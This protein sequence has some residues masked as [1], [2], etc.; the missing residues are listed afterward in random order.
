[1]LN[2][3]KF[4]KIKDN[5]AG[6]FW[7]VL[8]SSNSSKLGKDSRRARKHADT[9]CGYGP[10]VLQIF[11]YSHVAGFYMV[12][13]GTWLLDCDVQ[14]HWVLTLI[15]FEQGTVFRLCTLTWI[16]LQQVKKIQ[17]IYKIYSIISRSGCLFC[18]LH[19]SWWNWL[20]KWWLCI[21]IAISFKQNIYVFF[22]HLTVIKLLNLALNDN[23]NFSFQVEWQK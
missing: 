12:L 2:F 7:T 6:I 5:Q 21:S 1:M 14:T 23:R 8:S 18:L 15:K 22:F 16:A 4:L 11:I 13:A 10:A 3:C 20:L 17:D 9:G 19:S